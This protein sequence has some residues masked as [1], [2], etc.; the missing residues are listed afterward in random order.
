MGVNKMGVEVK[1]G[2]EEVHM[3]PF[4]NVDSSK[5]IEEGKLNNLLKQTF[6]EFG[7]SVFLSAG[8]STFGDTDIVTSLDLMLKRE[9]GFWSMQWKT[10][11][12]IQPVLW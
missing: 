7:Y 2:F 12:R 11:R 9:G 8:K 4:L 6:S 5:T 10:F 1:I 3:S